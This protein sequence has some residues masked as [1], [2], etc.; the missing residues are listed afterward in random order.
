LTLIADDLVGHAKLLKQPEHA[1][2][3]G[4]VEMMDGEHGWSPGVGASARR[5]VVPA[6]RWKV[7]MARAETDITLILS[8]KQIYP[9]NIYPR[10]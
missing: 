4:I 5:L 2:G 3:A 8:T 1:L 6:G 9:G 7:E 10:N